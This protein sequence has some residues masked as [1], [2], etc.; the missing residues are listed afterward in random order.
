M[1][2]ISAVMSFGQINNFKNTV[3]KYLF[4][5]LFVKRCF[6]INPVLY[7]FTLHLRYLQCDTNIT[8]DY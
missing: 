7:L 1:L 6:S 5:L 2:L 3:F 8:L 4:D